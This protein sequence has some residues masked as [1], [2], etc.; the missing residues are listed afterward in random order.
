[1]LFIYLVSTV[2]RAENTLKFSK[3]V[4]LDVDVTI[5]YSKNSYSIS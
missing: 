1:M 3:A 4:D 2:T 5:S